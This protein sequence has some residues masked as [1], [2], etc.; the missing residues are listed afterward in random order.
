MAET[1][2]LKDGGFKLG[3]R[4]EIKILYFNYSDVKFLIAKRMP[5]Q[6]ND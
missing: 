3:Y 6:N 5:R 4:N 1:N 2:R